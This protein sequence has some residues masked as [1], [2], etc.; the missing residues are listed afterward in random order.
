MNLSHRFV[1]GYRLE[2]DQTWTPINRLDDVDEKRQITKKLL[3]SDE[4]PD[5]FGRAIKNSPEK[6]DSS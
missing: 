6:M 2:Q 5:I 4:I 1:G 3:Q